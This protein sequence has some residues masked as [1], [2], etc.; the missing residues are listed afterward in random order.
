MEVAEAIR[1]RRALRALDSRP[2]DDEILSALVNAVVLSAS[3]FNN[4]PWNLVICSGE[5]SLRGVRAALPKGNAWATRAPL[6]VVVASREEDDCQLSDRRNYNLFDCGL[7]IGQMLLQATELGLVAHPIAGYDPAKVREALGIPD[8]H[9]IITL[10]VCGFH[11]NDDT[12]LSDKQ[13]V[14]EVARPSRKSVGEN[15]HM[16]RWGIPLR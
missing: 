12:L 2:I 3:C 5:E 10:V 7:S 8:D 15:F 6:I 16:D 1:R 4:Q 11:G 14:A 9:V 13:R